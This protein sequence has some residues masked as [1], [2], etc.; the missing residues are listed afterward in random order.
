MANFNN[1]E[2]I[3]KEGKFISPLYS[4]IIIIVQIVLLSV[5]NFLVTAGSFKFD[6]NGRYLENHSKDI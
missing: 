4:P 6:K 3:M 5:V 2:F 1:A